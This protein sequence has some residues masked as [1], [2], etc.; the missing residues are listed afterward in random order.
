M[1]LRVVFRENGK[2]YNFSINATLKLHGEM[3]DIITSHSRLIYASCKYVLPIRRHAHT[4][5][6]HWH[7][8]ILQQL[9]TSTEIYMCSTCMSHVQTCYMD[10]THHLTWYM[11]T[12]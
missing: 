1:Y 6:R 3:T 5:A 2:I 10:I 8:E 11:C 7:V 9:N 12:P 4:C